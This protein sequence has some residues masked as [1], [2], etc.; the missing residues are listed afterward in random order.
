[1]RHPSHPEVLKRLEAE[2]VAQAG[3]DWDAFRWQASQGQARWGS[4]V[5]PPDPVLQAAI[6]HRVR[7]VKH[8]RLRGWEKLLPSQRQELADLAWG[9]GLLRDGK[10]TRATVRS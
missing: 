2:L 10:P 1:M 6:W 3:A 7:L 8:A 4:G 9:L 5:K